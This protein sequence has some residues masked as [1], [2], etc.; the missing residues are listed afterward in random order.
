MQR[1]DYFWIAFAV[2]LAVGLWLT[3]YLVDHARLDPDEA[4]SALSEHPFSQPLPL[5]L[6]L[7]SK[8]SRSGPEAES[9]VGFVSL[10]DNME[11]EGAQGGVVV[12]AYQVHTSAAKA[13]SAFNDY[14]R[15]FRDDDVKVF[16]LG[17]IREDHMCENY[18]GAAYC[19]AVI[20]PVYMEANSRIPLFL[21]D[22]GF[23]LE[24]LMKSAIEH[25]NA[26]TAFS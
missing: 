18:G 23:H 19:Q 4:F 26:V 25:F 7:D 13:E 1:R 17:G 21:Q 5:D 12:I 9:L 3:V 8:N 14:W 10:A 11:T 16:T 15:H 2:F 22:E 20:G 6:T 24:R